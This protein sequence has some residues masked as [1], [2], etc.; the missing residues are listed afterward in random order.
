MYS[1]VLISDEIIK[2]ISINDG[3]NISVLEVSESFRV[4]E[5]GYKQVFHRTNHLSV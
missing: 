3:Q 1:V 5:N 4:N 2:T